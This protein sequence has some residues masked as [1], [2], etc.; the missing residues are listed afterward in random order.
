MPT[1]INSSQ[2]DYL[3][4]LQ[5]DNNSL[6]R[7]LNLVLQELDRVNRDRSSL[8][9]KFNIAA[10][11]VLQMKRMLNEEDLDDKINRD[12]QMDLNTLRDKN[13]EAKLR[14]ADID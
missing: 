2:T 4:Q 7:R 12:L 3:I 10:K 6:Q 1:P 13:K 11:D 8:S 5:N 14:I 9:Q